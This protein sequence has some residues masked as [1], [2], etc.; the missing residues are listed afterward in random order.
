MATVSARG[1]LRLS[2]PDAAAERE[3]RS[4]S[5]RNS[6][7]IVRWG[8]VLA[9]VLYA[10]FGILD[11]YMLPDSYR[12]VWAIRFA[13]VVPGVLL[14]LASTFL[15]SFER[16]S[17]PVLAAT[18]VLLAAGILL[19]MRVSNRTEQGYA[20]YYTGLLLVI[21]WIGTFS[22]LRF[23]A[24]ALCVAITLAGFLLVSIGNGM[25]RGGFANPDF[26]VFVN[27]SFFLL[28]AAILAVFSAWAFERSGRAR[29]LQA[30]ALL[31][32]QSRT[33]ML[34]ARIE[35][36]F[37]QQ[38]SAEVARELVDGPGSVESRLCQVSVMFLDIR[39]FTR[40]ADSREPRDVAAFQNA[41]FGEVIEIIRAHRG[42]TNQILGDGVMATFGAP[43]ENETNA[44]DAVAAGFAILR[45]IETLAAGGR[46]PQIRIGIG[47][48]AGRVLAGNIGNEH[49]KQYSLTG[50]TVNVAAR[51]EKMNKD[52]DSQFLVSGEV[53]RELDGVDGAPLGEI[54]LRGVADPV[55]LFRLA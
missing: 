37:G 22:Q 16:L 3:F 21:L 18:A 1:P 48:H 30:Q 6:L 50:S 25:V 13:A 20:S 39:D 42:I 33:Q 36:L 40:Y 53:F 4:A 38:V 10:A 2:F 23:Q 8:L 14:V 17:T 7:P 43:V 52:H 51:I 12:T 32:E 11:V 31:R 54:R 26:P 46:I 19:M 15:P 35:T 55:A 5:F 47:I 41:V 45:R 44:R 9:L 29:F 24:A 27:N 34:L 28:G 49:R